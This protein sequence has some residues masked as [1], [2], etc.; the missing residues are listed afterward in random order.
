MKRWL[1]RVGAV[2]LPAVVLATAV[3]VAPSF[4]GAF[5]TKQDA[6]AKFVSKKEAERT[7]LSNKVAKE[8]YA[9][10]VE[11]VPA[12]FVRAVP[13]TVDVGP[14][15]SPTPYVIPNARAYFKTES[16]LSD[17]VLTFSGQATCLAEKQGIGCPIQILIDGSPTGPPKTNVLTSTANAATAKPVE[18]AFTT[19]Q[20]GIVTPGKHEITV[21]YFGDNKDPSLAFKLLDWTLVAEVYPGD[22]IAPVEE[23]ETK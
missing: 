23:E 19:T 18:T 22:E 5:L 4:A 2:V 20:T 16:E 10:K 9:T 3:A 21:R 12:P 11:N 8:T 17:L 7:Y 15:T 13:S 14:L 1:S 6:S